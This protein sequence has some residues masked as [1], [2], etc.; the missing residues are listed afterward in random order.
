MSSIGISNIWYKLITLL[1]SLYH[2]VDATAYSRAHF[3]AGTGSIFL[4]DVSCSGTESRLIDCSHSGV[5]THNCGHSEDAGVSCLGKVCVVVCLE[6][7]LLPFE[8]LLNCEP[9]SLAFLVLPVL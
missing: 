2:V 6:W 3:G 8:R 4:D 9:I 1:H 7:K 5:G